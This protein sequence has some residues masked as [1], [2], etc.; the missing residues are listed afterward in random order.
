MVKLLFGAILLTQRRDGS[1]VIQLKK[2]LS[3]YLDQKLAV[4]KN[5]QATEESKPKP[6]VEN[7]AKIGPNKIHINIQTPQKRRKTLV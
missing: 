1:T 2:I 6:K 7:N 5:A 3:E 4:D